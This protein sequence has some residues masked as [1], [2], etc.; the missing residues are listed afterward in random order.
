MRAAFEDYIQN[1][2]KWNL[3]ESDRH[4]LQGFHTTFEPRKR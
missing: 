2:R 3:A 1:L 4:N